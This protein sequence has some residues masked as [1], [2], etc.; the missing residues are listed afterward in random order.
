MNNQSRLG[1]GLKNMKHRGHK[2]GT[3]FRREIIS[4]CPNVPKVDF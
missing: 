3:E 4:R 1:Q 2:V